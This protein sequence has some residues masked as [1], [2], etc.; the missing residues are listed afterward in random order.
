MGDRHQDSR[1]SSPS[2]S[3]DRRVEERLALARR[4]VRAEAK[5]IAGLESLLDERFSRAV[6]LILS[7]S[8]KVVVSGVGKAG[9]VGQKISATLASTGTDSI[10]LHPAEAV[11]GDLGR[12]RADDVLLALSNSGESVELLR[13]IPPARKIGSAVLGMTG[14]PRSSLAQLCDVVLEIGIVDEACPLGLAPTASTSAL[15]ALG[16]ALAMTLSSERRFSREDYALYHP[17]GSLGR[18]LLK[19]GEIMRQGSEVP[20]VKSGAPLFEVFRV[21]SRTPGRPGCALVVSDAGILIGIF[22]DGDLRRLLD[23]RGHLGREDS[24]DGYMVKSP[25]CVRPEQLVGEAERLLHEYRV[26]QMPV[27]D[28]RGHPV[29]LIDVQDLLDT[30]Y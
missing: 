24:I 28:E 10:F 19:I 27:V 16:D 9:L 26:D 15:L 29:G 22:T 13:M 8:G 20:L 3:G 6:D 11:H 2:A 12:I 14:A 25:K 17:A 18:K 4:V 5:T 1:P 30:R 21:M 23:D 7:R